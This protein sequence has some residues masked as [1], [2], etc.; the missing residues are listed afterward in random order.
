LGDPL[1]EPFDDLLQRLLDRLGDHVARREELLPRELL[2]QLGGEIEE[3]VLLVEQ[4]V[5]AGALRLA[6]L[7][8]LVE[9]A[10]TPCVVQAGRYAARSG[11]RRDRRRDRGL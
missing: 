9:P 3:V 5:G 11:G 8:R 1:L 10:Q 7:V 2:L 6:L 4:A